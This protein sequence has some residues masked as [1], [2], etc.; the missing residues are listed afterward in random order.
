M[1]ARVCGFVLNS[2]TSS[3]GGKKKDNT[4]GA[5]H[6]ERKLEAISLPREGGDACAGH[7]EGAHVLSKRRVKLHHARRWRLVIHRLLP[8]NSEDSAVVVPPARVKKSAVSQWKGRENEK[9]CVCVCVQEPHCSVSSELDSLCSDDLHQGVN[10]DGLAVALAA[11]ELHAARR[12]ADGE[13][14]AVCVNVPVVAIVPR[15]RR[16]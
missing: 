7:L 14:G 1:H 9:L 12:V 8:G 4:S 2:F 10:E 3:G 6:G 11:H 15:N 16:W 13:H 5:Y